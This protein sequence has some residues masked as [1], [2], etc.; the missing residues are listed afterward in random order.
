MKHNYQEVIEEVLK[1]KVYKAVKFVSEKLVIRATRTRYG[2]RLPK[3]DIE[4]TISVRRPNYVERDMIKKMRK[5]GS[6]FP[7]RVIFTKVVQVR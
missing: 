6:K 1:D 3:N 5:A 4:I 2:K 7:I